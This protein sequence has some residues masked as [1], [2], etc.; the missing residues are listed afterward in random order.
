MTI[1]GE[2]AGKK[3]SYQSQKEFV[4]K[5]V[6]LRDSQV[7]L[8]FLVVRTKVVTQNCSPAPSQSEAVIIGLET[9]TNP[10]S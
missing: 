5:L 2:K 10:F 1:G 9:H 6:K 4:T 8:D 3:G 7:K